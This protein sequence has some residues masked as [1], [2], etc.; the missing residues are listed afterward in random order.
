MKNNKWNLTKEFIETQYVILKKSLPT[1]SKETKIP[2]EII[3]YY[4]NKYNIKS[5][6]KE[7][8]LKGKRNSPKTEFKKGIIPWNKGKKSLKK[9]W[10]KGIKLSEEYK[11]KISESTKKAMRRPEIRNK[12]KKAQFKKGTIPWNKGKTKVYF[13][14]T[15][16][17]IRKK[18]LEQKFPKKDT[19][20]EL[21]IFNI[22]EKKQ[23]KF[24]KHKRIENICQADAFIKP[25]RVIFADGDYWH[26]NPKVF[27][28][29]K[30]DAQ[31]K[32]KIRDIKV[33]KR[34]KEKNYKV[35]RLWESEILKNEQSCIN[36]INKLI[37]VKNGRS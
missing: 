25:N 6:P 15:I 5:H 23:L 8:F 22:L 16:E 3:R 9:P 27:K 28:K 20:I 13:Q 14:E 26:T 2:F 21:I 34:L 18:R 24:E 29:P 31:K 10:N 1:I 32:N 12:V 36:K 11:R 17:K 33:N 37:K 4:K 35:L 7:F 30:T 19:K